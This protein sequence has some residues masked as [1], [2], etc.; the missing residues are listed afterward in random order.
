M[1]EMNCPKCGNINPDNAPVCSRC[2]QALLNETS[3]V[4]KPKISVLNLILFG[5]IVFALLTLSVVSIIASYITVLI[6][7]IYSINNVI[8][9]I[10]SERSRG[11]GKVYVATVMLVLMDVSLVCTILW[12]LDAPPIPNDYS[13]ADLRSAGA[14]YSNSYTI[15]FSL[16]PTRDT[17]G[18][19]LS[20]NDMN[21]LNEVWGIFIKKFDDTNSVMAEEIN[22][23]PEIINEIWEKANEGRDVINKLSEFEEIAD[24]TPPDMSA[25]LSFLVNFR[26]LARLYNLQIWLQCEQGDPHIGVR[27][28]VKFDSVVR[29]MSVNARSLV[30]K[31]VYYSCLDMNIRT[32]N[33]I[34]NNPRISQ[35]TLELL[36]QHFIPFSNDQVS[37][38]N[39][40]IFE[41][42][43]VRK[44]VREELVNEV[45]VLRFMRN[46]PFL[47]WNSTLRVCRNY[48]DEQLDIVGESDGTSN[49]PLSIW[50]E[51]YPDLSPVVMD[52]DGEILWYY[53]FYNPLGTRLLGIMLPSLSHVFRKKTA[54]EVKDD[55]LQIILNKR[56]DK[57]INLK[58]RTYSDEYIIDQDKKIIF[59]PGP[60]GKAYT[61]DDIK[62]PIDSRVIEF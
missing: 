42:I 41:Y 59:S 47:K 56:L 49:R 45:P 14:K 21:N 2:G 7:T 9:I 46:V 22:I 17:T 24:L 61:E 35:D 27:E 55:L 57:E 5:L 29:K 18:T 40:F 20:T 34:A 53:E 6:I 16:A 51:I 33:F 48:W 10:R 3:S 32:A 44:G 60:D 43:A 37:L 4:E 1:T 15:L 23:Q 25:N 13:I 30:T 12:H 58:A 26:R 62:L 36:A 38:R 50:P 11:R 39:A 54:L 19:G 52:S 8:K 28:L 31:F